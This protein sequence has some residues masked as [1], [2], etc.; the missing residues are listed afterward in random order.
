[1]HTNTRRRLA[2]TAAFFFVRGA[3]M[4]IGSGAV[5]MLIWWIQTH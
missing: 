5:T 4:A 1:M 3:A 2:R